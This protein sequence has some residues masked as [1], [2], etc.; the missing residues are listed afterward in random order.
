MSFAHTSPV[1]L[2]KFAAF[3]N[4][5]AT[6][7]DSFQNLFIF[8]W[9]LTLLQMMHGLSQGSGDVIVFD[10]FGQITG[11]VNGERSGSSGFCFGVS[12]LCLATFVLYVA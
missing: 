2:L 12:T 1:S 8:P 6:S 3:N 4:L 11:G 5:P 7:E 10:L 9:H